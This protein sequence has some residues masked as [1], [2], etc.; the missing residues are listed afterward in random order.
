MVLNVLNGSL[1]FL[2][3]RWKDNWIRSSLDTKTPLWIL[4]VYCCPIRPKIGQLNKSNPPKHSEFQLRPERRFIICRFELQTVS[5]KHGVW[6]LCFCPCCQE[7]TITEHILLSLPPTFRIL[8]LKFKCLKVGK[9]RLLTPGNNL[10]HVY[11][12]SQTPKN[13]DT[14]WSHKPGY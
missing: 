6:F 1:Y 7:E 13:S 4:L 11:A 12:S 9:R 3:L 14:K 8:N 5:S 10:L 2:L